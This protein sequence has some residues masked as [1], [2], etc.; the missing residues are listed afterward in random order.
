TLR[1][2]VFSI[3]GTGLL[4]YTSPRLTI[5]MT[6]AVPPIA[7]ATSMLGRRV[8]VLASDVHAAYADA[9]AAAAEVLAGV[10]T[11]RAFSQEKRERGRYDRQL[12]RALAAARRKVRARAALGGVSLIA[13]E[14][15]AVLAIWVGGTQIAAGRMTTGTLISF[16]LYALLVARGFRNASRFAAEAP[17][18]IGATGRVFERLAREPLIRL[19]G[20]NRP[21]A[22][23]GSVVLEDVRFRY[24]SRP[25][26]EALKG[27][28][29]DIAPGE[30]VA[31][32]GRSGSGKSTIL[33]L[34]LRFYDP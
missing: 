5:L 1:S 34:I 32:V 31:L 16:I 8:K 11:V 6:L 23:D 28:R 27:I 13:G 19:Q 30:T 14:C 17:R 7:F 21:A 29:L 4:L 25:A 3:L 9:G 22:F 24:P 2:A 15:A 18:P 20:G 10:R 12:A 33:S 26:V